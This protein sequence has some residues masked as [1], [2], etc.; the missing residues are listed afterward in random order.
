MGFEAKMTAT[1]ETSSKG[2]PLNQIQK[3]VAITQLTV[4]QR[5]VLSKV[6]KPKFL[7]AKGNNIKV[8]KK[9]RHT[10]IIDGDKCKNLTR[11][12]AV[13]NINTDRSSVK[14]YINYLQCGITNFL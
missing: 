5:F 9:S 6:S 13:D 12:G 11:E 8:T 14:A 7:Y 10:K 3:C 4:R 2:I 1:E